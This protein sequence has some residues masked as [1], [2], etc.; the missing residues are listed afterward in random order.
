MPN[1]RR[2]Q[3]ETGRIAPSKWWI[4]NLFGGKKAKMSAADDAST[5]KSSVNSEKARHH[6]SIVVCS[7]S[8]ITLSNNHNGNGNKQVNG[9]QI[10]ADEI[11]AVPDR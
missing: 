8:F 9:K 1:K 4:T 11:T 10:Q 5:I 2:T 6:H 7:L 3:D